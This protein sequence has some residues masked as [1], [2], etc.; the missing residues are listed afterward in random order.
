MLLITNFSGLVPL[1]LSSSQL[2]WETV[3]GDLDGFLTHFETLG[4]NGPLYLQR[5]NPVNYI[6]PSLSFL[7]PF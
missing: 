2:S 4:V 5:I 3:P 1:T 7:A 6:V